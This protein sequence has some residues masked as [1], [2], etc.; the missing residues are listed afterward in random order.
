[1][2]LPGVGERAVLVG[3]LVEG[4]V[5]GSF[6]VMFVDVEDEQTFVAG[7]D[8]DAVSSVEAGVPVGDGVSVVGGVG[9]PGGHGWP[10]VAGFDGE[11]V[12]AVV[13]EPEC[14]LVDGVVGCVGGFGH[15]RL[16]SSFSMINSR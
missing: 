5:A 9:L 8:A 15:G 7:G 13:G 6:G 10:F 1:V 12:Q 4:V 2:N 14:F 3:E 11:Y 16:P